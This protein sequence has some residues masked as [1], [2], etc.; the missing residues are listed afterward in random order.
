MPPAIC[1][2]VATRIDGVVIT[3]GTDTPDETARYF[4]LTCELPVVVT[5]AQRRP[6][7]LGSDEA[8]NLLTAV[9][10]IAHERVTGGTFEA[11]N[12]GLHTAVTVRKSRTCTLGRFRSPESEPIARF[13]RKRT[14]WYR[15]LEGSAE[16]FPIPEGHPGSDAPVSTTPGHGLT[17]SSSPEPVSETRLRSSATPSLRPRAR[18]S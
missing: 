18:S 13:T 10:A 11:F 17:D 1:V 4:D 12:E 5:G 9:E 8:T 7:E 14:H 16:A 2:H 15:E 6:G 3:H